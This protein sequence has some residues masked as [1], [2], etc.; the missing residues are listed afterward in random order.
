MMAHMDGVVAAEVARMV[1]FWIHVK[2][3]P[4]GFSDG[5]DVTCEE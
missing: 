1:R 3:K 4:V 5:Q 2:I